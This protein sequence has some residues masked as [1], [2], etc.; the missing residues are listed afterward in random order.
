M[1]ETSS[2]GALINEYLLGGGS[3]SVPFGG[4]NNSGLGKSFGYHGFVEFSNERP[5]MERKSLDLSIA[6]PP[7]TNK[8]KKLVR[9]IYRW[10]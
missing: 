6:Y 8:V 7:Y 9:K 2:G 10:L 4:V 5:V 1:A 3:A